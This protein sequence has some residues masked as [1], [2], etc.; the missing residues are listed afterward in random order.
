M[1]WVDQ[2]A[3]RG[4]D[5]A[6]FFLDHGE[7][8]AVSTIREVCFCCPVIAECAEYALANFE[9]FGIWGGLTPRERQAV[10]NGRLSLTQ[11]LERANSHVDA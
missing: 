2:A 7:G 1:N 5:P 10:R 9:E 3:C 4:I 8:V 6:L 11:H